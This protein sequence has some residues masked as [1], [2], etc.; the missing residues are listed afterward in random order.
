MGLY[1]W[2]RITHRYIDGITHRSR[3]A[4]PAEHDPVPDPTPDPEL[5]LF[6]SGPDHPD[7]NQ[8]SIF[9]TLNLSPIKC[10]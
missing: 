8:K 6:N 2:V 3:V 7:Q 9:Q 1:L 4:D 5:I 10:F